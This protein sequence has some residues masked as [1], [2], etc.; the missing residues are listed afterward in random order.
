ME[1]WCGLLWDIHRARERR[2]VLRAFLCARARVGDRG[3]WLMGTVSC[4][5]LF[6]VVL[7]YRRHF[8]CV[9]EGNA[10]KERQNETSLI[11]MGRFSL[12]LRV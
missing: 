7:V 6:L 9:C 4:Y 12:I 11:P 5:I 1:C 2:A 8:L 3:E 10:K